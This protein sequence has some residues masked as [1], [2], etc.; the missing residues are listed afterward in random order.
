MCPNGKHC[1]QSN[2]A[3]FVPI[4]NILSWLKNQS[5]YSQTLFELSLSFFFLYLSAESSYEPAKKTSFITFM[6]TP[7]FYEKQYYSTWLPALLVKHGPECLLTASRNQRQLQRRTVYSPR[8][9]EIGVQKE[10]FQTYMSNPLHCVAGR[11][12]GF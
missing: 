10:E 12:T 4:P 6:V 7:H 5:V 9:I 8:A 2:F 1:L 11:S 3:D